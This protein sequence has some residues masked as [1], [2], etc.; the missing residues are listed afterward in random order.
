VARGRRGNPHVRRDL[1][2]NNPKK[3]RSTP[4]DIALISS[5]L[6]GDGRRAKG[7]GEEDD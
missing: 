7:E 4:E 5:E 3:G 6:S 1:R 2:G